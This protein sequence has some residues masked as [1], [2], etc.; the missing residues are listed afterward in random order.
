MFK[1][2]KS[3][4]Q[5]LGKNLMFCPFCSPTFTAFLDFQVFLP[6]YLR[7]NRWVNFPGKVLR[8]KSFGKSSSEKVLREKF[9]GIMFFG[10]KFSRI[11]FCGKL[12]FPDFF[13]G[14]IKFGIYPLGN[15]RSEI[16]SFWKNTVRSLFVRNF[17]FRQ[18][19]FPA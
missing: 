10:I 4:V 1:S 15:K 8:E 9:S 17:V 7:K 5:D 16:N 6:R 12:F 11:K 18:N 14:K 3:I 2:V 13:S 19:V